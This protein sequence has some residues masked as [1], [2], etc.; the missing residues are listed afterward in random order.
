MIF[1]VLKCNLKAQQSL[2][3]VRTAFGAEAPCKMTIYNWFA[4]FKRGRVNLRDEFRDGR[5]STAANNKNIDAVRRMIDTD[6]H[7]T[8][9]E[10]RAS[11]GIGMNQTQSILH[12][13][14]GMKKLCSQQISYNLVDAQEQPVWCNALF[15]RFKVQMI[16][17]VHGHSRLGVVTNALPASWMRDAAGVPHHP[18]KVI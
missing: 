10:I 4:E 8:Y 14:L 1:Y 3:R 9:H 11:L 17:A 5:P 2:A 13:D 15:T 7:V 6:R 16:T 12:K 18:P